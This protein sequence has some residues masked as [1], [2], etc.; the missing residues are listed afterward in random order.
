MIKYRLIYFLNHPFRNIREGFSHIKWAFQRVYRGWDDRAAYGMDSFL[1][2][3][4][5]ELITGMKKYGNSY[6]GDIG[7]DKWI[8]ELNTISDGFKAAQRVQ[9]DDFPAWDELRLSDDFDW[10]K[11]ELPETFWPKLEKEQDL[12]LDTFYKGMDKFVEHFW[13]LWD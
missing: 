3:I 12:A 8:E 9:N 4:I 2:K 11:D 10:G 1:A 13:D 6:P 5:P 7:P